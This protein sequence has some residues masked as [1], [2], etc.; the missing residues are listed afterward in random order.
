MMMDEYDDRDERYGRIAC[1]NGC[2]KEKGEPLTMYVQ[3]CGP[4]ATTVSA[5]APESQP[6]HDP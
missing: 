2:R 3:E 6:W 5:T 4:L 1:I